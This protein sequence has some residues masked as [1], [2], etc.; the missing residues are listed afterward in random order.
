VDKHTIVPWGDVNIKISAFQQIRI[1][2]PSEATQGH[3][4]YT[5]VCSSKWLTNVYL[6]DV[7]IEKEAK[8]YAKIL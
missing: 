5:R 2:V 7:K 4:P 8:T 1:R 6:N 3:Y